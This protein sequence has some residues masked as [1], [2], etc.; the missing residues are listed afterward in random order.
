MAFVPLDHRL[1]QTTV[2]GNKY[3]GDPVI[4]PM[5]HRELDHWRMLHPDYTYW[6]GIQLG[7]CGE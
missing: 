7:G 6:C 4:L 1:V 5:D 3:S 2:I